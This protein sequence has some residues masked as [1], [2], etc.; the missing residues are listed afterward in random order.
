MEDKIYNLVVAMSED[1]KELK[2]QVKRI[3]DNQKGIVETL[4]GK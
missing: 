4:K 2:E 1:M 3:E